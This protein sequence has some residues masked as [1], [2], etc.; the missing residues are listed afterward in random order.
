MIITLALMTLV[1]VYLDALTIILFVMIIIL[2]LTT[3]ARNRKA[4]KQI[5][6]LVMIIT[7]VQLTPV[8]LLLDVS[9]LL[10]FVTTTTTV[11]LI[12]ANLN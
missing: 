5:T 1:I 10:L 8:I 12:F 2:V 4:V 6:L 7:L 3:C 11:Q 9:T